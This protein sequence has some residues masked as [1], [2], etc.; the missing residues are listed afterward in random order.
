MVKTAYAAACASISDSEPPND[1]WQLIEAA[2]CDPNNPGNKGQYWVCFD[3]DGVPAKERYEY[4]KPDSSCGG[5][6]DTDTGSGQCYACD[7]GWW[8][9]GGCAT[10]PK[11]CKNGDSSTYDGCKSG[12]AV[13]VTASGQKACTSAAGGG[14]TGKITKYRIAENYTALQAAGYET[15]TA[16][17]IIRSFTFTDTIPGRK[18][19]FVQFKNDVGTQSEHKPFYITLLGAGP[20]IQGAIACQY[21]IKSDA[22]SL[23][24]RGSNF[25]SEKG[26]ISVNGQDLSNDQKDDWKDD[27]IKAHINRPQTNS[28]GS[29]VKIVV[30][31]PD[32]QSTEEKTC[33]VN[34]TQFDIGAKWKCG[35][36]NTQDVPNTVLTVYDMGIQQNVGV[37]TT[38][39]G[40]TI[41]VSETVVI[42]KDG[43]IKNTK[44]KLNEGATYKMCVKPPLGLRT[45]SDAFI[46]SPGTIVT[47]LNS[48]PIGNMND[49]ICI[50]K[51]DASTVKTQWGRGSS[52]A[53]TADFNS[54]GAVNSFEWGCMMQ[55]FGKCDTAEPF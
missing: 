26:K 12:D 10:N 55:G 15:Y 13:G 22:L 14:T 40:T 52:A 16:G 41:K 37:G 5:D 53:K 17:G 36:A 44:T 19:V 33:G 43:T 9:P 31:K 51:F 28:T 24:V 20:E 2:Q 50:D 23:T 34:I 35:V 42:S 7:A 49:D 38:A 48:I 39:S 30:T 4:D 3:D 1:G 54:D 47:K 8:R 11:T 25:G 29:K 18:A 45:C 32:G 27:M 46:F 21:D 6:T